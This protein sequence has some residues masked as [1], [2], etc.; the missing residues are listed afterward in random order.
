MTIRKPEHHLVAAELENSAQA[1]LVLTEDATVEP[2]EI[3][4]IELRLKY[5]STTAFNSSDVMIWFRGKNHLIV[6]RSLAT[7]QSRWRT[8]LQI[9]FDPT[10]YHAITRIAS[11]ELC[12]NRDPE[13]FY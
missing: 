3:S 4:F 8:V 12:P 5:V 11:G 6:G 7:K 9:E 1:K 2:A 13:S 10:A